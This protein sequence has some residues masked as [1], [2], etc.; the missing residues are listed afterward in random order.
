M[1]IT[2]VKPRVELSTLVK[3]IWVF[4]SP[5]GMP[6][7][8]TSLAAPNGSPKLI[9]N[10]ENSIISTAEGRAEK[11]KEQ[12]LYFVGNRDVPVRLSTPH[13]KTGFIGIEFYPHGAYPIFGIPMLK[14]ANQRFQFD[15]LLDNW[16]KSLSETLRN[17]GSIEGKI[18]FI[19]D[20]LLESL[21]K[22][23]LQSSIVEYCV[24]SL[25]S[26]HG[27]MQISEMER[28]TGY[29]RRYLELLF[30]NHVGFS[31]KVL[32]GIFRF[33]KFYKKWAS[34]KTYSD[35][36]DELNDYYFDQAHFTKEFKRMTGFSPLQFTHEVSNE[37]GRLF[38]IR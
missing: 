24:N 17:I 10:C 11:S 27:L 20:K 33:Q 36:K 26:T 8:D 31:P 23:Q 16:G 21:E 19:Q 2:F 30:K 7:S 29:S 18:Y 38:S 6:V 4:E 28:K 5:V 32:A 14:T 37:F 13:G 25:K 12:G 15:E 34:G 9:I 35:L 3:F 1:K 22:K